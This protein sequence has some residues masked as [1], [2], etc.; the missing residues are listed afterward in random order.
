MNNMEYGGIVSWLPC[1][2]E[3]QYLEPLFLNRDRIG[4]S[5]LGVR[6]KTRTDR[7]DCAGLERTVK[8]AKAYASKRIFTKNEL[9]TGDTAWMKLSDENEQVFKKLIDL[10]DLRNQTMLL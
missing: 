7:H 8:K 4:V 2:K 9:A 1:R 3:R 10:V 5:T 6:Q